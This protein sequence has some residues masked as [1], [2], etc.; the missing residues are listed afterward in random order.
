MRIDDPL[1]ELVAKKAA[2]R[3]E[4]CHYPEEF[5]PS[6]FEVDH[7]KPRSAGGLLKLSNLALACSHCNAHKAKRET[8]VDPVTK[9]TVQ[10]F[11]P[12]TDRWSKSFQLDRTT[13]KIEGLTPVGRATVEVL[14][15][16]DVQ[17]LTARRHLIRLEIL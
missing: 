5:S 4:Y 13:G 7:I 11:P 16:N 6:S 9:K 12:H 2:F 1:R 14:H 17:P 10:L 15:M 8:G 3:C